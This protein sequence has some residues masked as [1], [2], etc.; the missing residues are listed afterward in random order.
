MSSA[1]PAR[2]TSSDSPGWRRHLAVMRETALM[3]ARTRIQGMGL[4]G[5][6]LTWLTLPLMEMLVLAFIYRS[7]RALLEYAVVA[8]AGNAILFTLIFNGG[9][10]LDSERRRGTLG[11]LFLA[12]LPRFVWL[13]GFQLFALVEALA[14]AAIA[15]AAGAWWFDVGL[16]VNVPSLAVTVILLTAALWGL[17]LILGA[18]GIVVRNANFLSNLLFPFLSL[19][20]GTM[21]PVARMPDWVRIPARALPFSY[22]IE[23]LVA[24]LTRDASVTDL[25]DSLLP[26]LGFAVVLPVLGV[27]MF[28]WME[29]AVRQIG[30]LE[31]A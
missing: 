20:A 29:R 11:N 24:A 8:S 22:G 19:F 10:I 12:P 2:S 18:F 7:D 5:Y 14:N 6:A 3:I 17:S 9:E 21:Y 16:A 23:A 15:I 26:L 25:A 30:S 4:P 1:A 13:G 31:I 28:R 27:L